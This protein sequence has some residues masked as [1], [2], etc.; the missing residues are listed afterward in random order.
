[1]VCVHLGCGA[2]VKGSSVR[3]HKLI[4]GAPSHLPAKGAVCGYT[5]TSLPVQ[6]CEGGGDRGAL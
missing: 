4:C 1:M 6:P 3:I 2:A 5:T